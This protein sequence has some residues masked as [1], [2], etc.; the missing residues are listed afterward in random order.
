WLLVRTRP[1]GVKTNPDP[2]ARSSL[3]R[4]PDAAALGPRPTSILTTAGPTIS[5][6]P[7]TAREYASRS[8]SSRSTSSVGIGVRAADI[9]QSFYG[10][11]CWAAPPIQ[12]AYRAFYASA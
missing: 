10:R 8:E 3:P 1:S 6:A 11:E 5:T 12:V 4:P 7:I 9:T 2:P